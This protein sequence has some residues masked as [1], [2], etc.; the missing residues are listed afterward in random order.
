MASPTYTYGFDP[1]HNQVDQIRLWI[2]DTTLSFNA[3]RNMNTMQLADQE[4]LGFISECSSLYE[5]AASCCEAL[6]VTYAGK[7]QYLKAIGDIK[8]MEN[9]MKQHQNYLAMADNIRKRH[10]YYQMGGPAY[11]PA[12]L[13]STAENGQIPETTDFWTGQFDNQNPVGGADPD[14][15]SLLGN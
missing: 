5:A 9:F 15:N 13:Q 7:H 12:A 8:V 2:F 10:V 6:A 3:E 11:V 14:V 1:I 4:I